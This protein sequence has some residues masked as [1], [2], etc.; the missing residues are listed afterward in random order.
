MLSQWVKCPFIPLKYHRYCHKSCV[1]VFSIPKTIIWTSFHF[2][3]TMF[4]KDGI[5]EQVIYSW[6]DLHFI[7]CRPDEEWMTWPSKPTFSI[8]M[9]AT[10]DY[11]HMMA[12]DIVNTMVP[13]LS[14][15]LL[16]YC[17]K[18]NVF[19]HHGNIWQIFERLLLYPLPYH[20]AS[21]MLH[22]ATTLGFNML[23]IYIM[24]HPLKCASARIACVH[25][26]GYFTN[27][28]W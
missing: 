18:A 12:R 8:L 20:V 23:D 2:A 14:Q 3:S 26:R 15:Y 19:I 5:F 22:S 13:R 27:H 24:K 11:A 28:W 16:Y 7:Q 21:Y 1:I 9:L 10:W 25:F 6:A 17:N 4:N